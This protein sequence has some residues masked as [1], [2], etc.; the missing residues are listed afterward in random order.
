MARSP[1]VARTVSGDVGTVESNGRAV[2]KAEN[3][4]PSSAKAGAWRAWPTKRT[5]WPRA[6]SSAAMPTAGGTLPPPSQVTNRMSAMSVSSLSGA[7]HGTD[8]RLHPLLCG[9]ARVAAVAAQQ[10]PRVDIG[11]DHQQVEEVF[12]IGDDVA[13]GG[14][15][16]LA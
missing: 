15:H 16:P 2:G 11:R 8:Q 1:K 10:L 5:R 14:A 12:A 9:G 13:E 7:G 3:S 6:S 4:S